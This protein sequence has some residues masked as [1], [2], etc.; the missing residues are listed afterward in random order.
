MKI[1]SQNPLNVEQSLSPPNDDGGIYRDNKIAMIQES[2]ARMA[3]DDLTLSLRDH[4][5]FLSLADRKAMIRAAAVL[6]IALEEA[7]ASV[8]DV[9]LVEI[10]VEDAMEKRIDSDLTGFGGCAL[11]G[12]AFAVWSAVCVCAGY[13]FALG[14][15]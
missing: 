15:L 2:W 4:A 11:L 14:G 7:A 3:I 6:E 9:D 13:W 8:A 5:R 12:S 1:S 10:Q